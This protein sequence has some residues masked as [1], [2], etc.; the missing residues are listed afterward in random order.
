VTASDINWSDIWAGTTNCRTRYLDATGQDEQTSSEQIRASG[1][2]GWQ[3]R[4]H[5]EPGKRSRSVRLGWMERLVLF[6]DVASLESSCLSPEQGP[7]LFNIVKTDPTPGRLW[8]Q[9][10]CPW[11]RQLVDERAADE[12]RS[13]QAARCMRRPRSLQWFGRAAA[14]VNRAVGPGDVCSAVAPSST[15]NGPNGGGAEGGGSIHLSA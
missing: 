15:R 8:L 4:P 12:A 2:P 7:A 11:G 3:R 9:T 5:H 13:S 1:C 6:I 10:L 14:S